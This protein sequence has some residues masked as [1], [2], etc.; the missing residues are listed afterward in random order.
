MAVLGAQVRCAQMS[1]QLKNVLLAV[2]AVAVMAMWGLIITAK[3]APVSTAA[4]VT[5]VAPT[6][7]HTHAPLSRVVFIGDSYTGGSSMNSPGR[8]SLYPTLLAAK[9][10]FVADNLAVS[11]TGYLAPGTTNQPFGSQV[12]AVVALHPNVVVLEGGHN[13]D[14]YPQAQVKAAASSVLTGLRTALPKAKIIVL[15]PIWPSGAAPQSERNID[16]DLRQIAVAG[17]ASFV[18]PIADGW[19]VG[20]YIKLIGSDGTLPT[21]AGQVRIAQLLGPSFAA[22]MPKVAS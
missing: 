22:T 6:P 18:D 7:T 3:G 13:D 14:N 17:G 9:F 1:N 21:D 8:A 10:G 15:G 20:P 2:A 19:F 4:L 16:A 11:G 5:A 12:A